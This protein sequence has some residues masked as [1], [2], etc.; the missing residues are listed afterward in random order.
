MSARSFAFV[1]SAVAACAS[2]AQ[3]PAPLI[4]DIEH[5]NTISLNGPWH[6]IVDPYDTG[7]KDYRSHVRSQDGFFRNAKPPTPQD[8]IEYA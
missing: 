6:A 7:R 1:L 3:Q 8:L 5:R 4:T 2:F